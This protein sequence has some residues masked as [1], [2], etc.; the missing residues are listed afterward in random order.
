MPKHDKRWETEI[1][2]VTEMKMVQVYWL[3]EF[4]KRKE[5]K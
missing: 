2:K 5:S 4:E 1:L 3:T